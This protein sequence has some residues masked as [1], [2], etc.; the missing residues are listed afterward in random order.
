MVRLDLYPA[1][2]VW[3]YTPYMA[4]DVWVYRYSNVVVQFLERLF[5]G[6]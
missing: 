4:P 5:Q 6:L 2:V 3:C 1:N